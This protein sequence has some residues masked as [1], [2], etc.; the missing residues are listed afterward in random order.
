MDGLYLPV[1]STIRRV[2]EIPEIL[3]LV[4]SFLDDKSNANNA[5][6]CRRWS[7]LALNILWRDVSDI[8]RAFSLLAPMKLMP[9][10]RFELG[11]RYVRLQFF[12]F[13]VFP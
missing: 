8:R 13:L 2:L 11:E 10:S 12:Y 3:E 7:Q 6:V 4:F 9:P 1:H 5:A